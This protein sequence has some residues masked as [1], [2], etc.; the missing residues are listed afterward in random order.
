MKRPPTDLKILN[1]IYDY[2]YDSYVDFRLNNKEPESVTNVYVPFDYI[3]VANH[4]EIDSGLLLGRLY[5]HLKIKYSF[6]Q[7]GIA[8][9]LFD[10]DK[11]QHRVHFP[12]LTAV[13]AELK[14]KQIRFTFPVLITAILSVAALIISLLK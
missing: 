13:L 2:Y 14:E 3:K 9:P 1:T 7:Q 5:Y 12:L 10:K 6:D 4:L 8:V 11:G